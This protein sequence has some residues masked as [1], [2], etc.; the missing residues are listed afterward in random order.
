MT[1]TAIDPAEQAHPAPSAGTKRVQGGLLDP[2]MLWRSTPDALRKLDPRTLWRNP[3]MFIVEIGAAWSTVLAIVGPTWFA[4]LTVIWLWLTVLF[5]NLAEAVAEGRGKAQ[6][7][8]LRRAKTQTMARRLRDWAPGS[9]GIEEAVAATALQQGDIVVVEAGQVIPGDGDVVEGIASVDESAITGESAPVIRESGGDRSA[10]TGGTTVLSDRIVVQITQK[11]GESF[12]DRMIALVEGANRQKTPN[13]IALNILLA[14][15][16]IIF[17]FAVATLQPLAIYSKVNNPGV[18]DTQALNTSGV[19]GIVM[20][21]LLVC[22]IPTT[23]GALLSAIGIAGM[24]RLVQRNVLAMSGRAVEAAGDV[25]TL[26]LDKTGTITL[27][28]RQAAAFIPLAGVSPEELADAAQLSS[29]A[30]ETPEGRSVVVFAKQHFGLR[31]RTPGELSQ[32][33]WVAFSAT[34][35][36]SGVDLDGHSLRKGAASSVAEW[37]RSQRGS[38]PHQ[39]GEIVDGISAGGGT[40]LVVGESVDGRARVLGV[41]HLKDVVKQGMRERFDEMRRMGIRTVM[42]TGDNPLTAKA[43]ADEA[44][45]DDFLAEA[46]P[47]DKLQL[48]KREQAGGKLVAMTGDGTNDAPA[49]AQ[50]DVGVAMN[51]GTSAA[52]EAGNM[53]DL[54]SDPTKLIEIV[55]I[56]KQLLITRGAL[57]TFSIANDIAK[58][59]A[60]IPAMFVALFPGLDLINV[61]RLH[62][63]QSAIL[64]AVIFNAIIIVLLIPLSLRGVR[65]TPSSASKLLSRNLY[66][67]GLGGIVAPFIGIKAIDL[68][69]Q[70]VPGMS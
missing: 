62:S 56:G 39:L 68:I 46:T 50:A 44:G 5:A 60:I 11:P 48:I 30:D 18:P 61:M 63:P 22:L 64:S 24:D 69:V 55:E 45:V 33:Q 53:V 67:Y 66:I 10:V 21:S 43:I 3:V 31:A 25:N 16:T 23:I 9:A 49:L 14:A 54:D 27:G 26:L 12:I 6:A 8:T 2:K 57:T 40:P 17:V 4:W 51:T 58:Y 38:V 20:V 29:L 65:Y 36:M 1:V 47:E 35:R 42:I 15:L 52:K 34:T 37:V 70:F 41:I 19:T 28:N 32:A 7:E 13:E 59:F